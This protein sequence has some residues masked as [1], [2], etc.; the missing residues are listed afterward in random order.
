M[1]KEADPGDQQEKIIDTEVTKRK[2]PENESYEQV[3]HEFK[4]QQG[5][6]GLGWDVNAQFVP[7][8]G[9]TGKSKQNQ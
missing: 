4:N 3:N 9:N 2:A 1:P 5:D 7:N 8:G 6:Q